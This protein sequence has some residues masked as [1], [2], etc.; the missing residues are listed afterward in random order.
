MDAFHLSFFCSLF[1][2]SP[3]NIMKNIKSVMIIERKETNKEIK[4][5]EENKEENKEIKKK[6]KK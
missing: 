5:K 4:D 1:T 3:K 2:F 6:N